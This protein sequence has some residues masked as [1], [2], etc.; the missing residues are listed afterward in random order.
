MTEV[1]KRAP[2]YHDNYISYQKDI[3]DAVK[4]LN[5]LRKCDLT[6]IKSLGAPPRSI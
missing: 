2:T 3:D 4:A 1:V 6:E 5:S